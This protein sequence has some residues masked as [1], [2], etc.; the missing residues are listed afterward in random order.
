MNQMNLLGIW[1]EKVFK[2]LHKLLIYFT[3]LKL[4]LC[5]YCN[6]MI[7]MCMIMY[8]LRVKFFLYIYYII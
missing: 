7:V 5:I 3:Q 4:L 8:L 1:F 2:H 6:A